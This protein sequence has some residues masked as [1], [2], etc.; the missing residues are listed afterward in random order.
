MNG[1]SISRAATAAGV[2]VETIRF[3]ERRGLIKQPLKPRNGGFRSYDTGVVARIR[4]IR[5]AQEI[6]FSLHEIEDLLALEANPKADCS[7][8]RSQAALK[9]NE[10]LRKITQLKAMEQALNRLIA[11]CPGSGALG[12]CTILDTLA[13]PCAPKAR[14]IANG[15]ATN[16]IKKGRAMKTITFA[17]EGMHCEACART[18]RALLQTEPGVKGVGVSF[19]RKNARIL[20][21]PETAREAALRDKIAKAGYRVLAEPHDQAK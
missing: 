2:G 8:V 18:V 21:D 16:R 3:Y 14:T 13:A 15:A 7:E 5:Q 4:F 20:I 10:V 11:A 17:I 12:A 6:G 9:R 19:A 1:M